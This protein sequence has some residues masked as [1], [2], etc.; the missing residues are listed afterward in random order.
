M[1]S[2]K[3]NEGQCD[4]QS[5]FERAVVGLQSEWFCLHHFERRLAK[6]RHNLDALN[7]LIARAD[8]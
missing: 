3:T 8:G 6:L 2:V 1:N 5:C 7:E 4:E